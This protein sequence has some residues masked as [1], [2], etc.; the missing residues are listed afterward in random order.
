[1]PRLSA[2]PHLL[3]TYSDG[4]DDVGDDPRRRPGPRAGSPG[5]RARASSQRASL[6][7][8][9]GKAAGACS[10]AR[11]RP[12]PPNTS[13]SPVTGRWRLPAFALAALAAVVVAGCG[14]I[15]EAPP[16]RGELIWSAPQNPLE[17]ATAAGL[18]PE[19]KE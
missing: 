6:G 3:R 16:P 5:R 8:P 14:L 12:R 19:R 13:R 10:R 15:P 2:C 9:H 1:M 18:Q 4:R 7:S 11:G 17:Q